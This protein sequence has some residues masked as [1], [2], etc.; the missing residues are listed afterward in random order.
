M[1]ID[2]LEDTVALEQLASEYWYLVDARGGDGIGDL[3]IE[4]G[5]FIL[6]GRK[7][8]G[9]TAIVGFYSL[10]KSRGPRGSL[11]IVT[12]FLPRFSGP[13]QAEVTTSMIAYAADGVPPFHGTLPLAVA[14]TTDVCRKEAD[15]HWRYASRNLVLLFKSGQEATLPPLPPSDQTR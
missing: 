14:T 2:R 5:I 1:K 3:W 15:G 4:D 9:R 11:H 10:R 12:N 8:E 6:D 7:V 13:D